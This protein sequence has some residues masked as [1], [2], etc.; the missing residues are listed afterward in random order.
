MKTKR[1]RVKQT[2]KQQNLKQ[3]HDSQN[4]K[5][6]IVGRLKLNSTKALT[7]MNGLN[8]L[9]TTGVVCKRKRYRGFHKFSRH[10]KGRL[11]TLFFIL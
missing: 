11:I 2:L 8:K 5:G 10:W 3:V 9:Y 4:K 1:Q 6:K 7:Q